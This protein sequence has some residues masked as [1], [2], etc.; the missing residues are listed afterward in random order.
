VTYY[1]QKLGKWRKVSTYGGKLAENITQA[2]ARDILA[3]AMLRL[4]SKGFMIVL[5]VH[6][7]I[8]CEVGDINLET[9]KTEILDTVTELPYWA[10]VE[11]A[12]PI[13]AKIW[14][15]KRYRK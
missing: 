14:A 4:N 5:H 3:E 9:D 15:G 1:A 11:P 13:S 8:V 6:D 12:L 10:E 2:V 7:E